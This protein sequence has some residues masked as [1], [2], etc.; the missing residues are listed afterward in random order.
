MQ[1]L[2][3]AR[4]VAECGLI[5]DG[6]LLMDAGR[7]TGLGRAGEVAIPKGSAVLD[8]RGLIAGPGLVDIHC[9][10]GGSTWCYDDPSAVGR[11]HLAGGTTSLCCSLYHA[12][13]FPTTVK[14]IGLIRRAC[15]DREPGNIVGIHFEGPYLSP[16][17]GASAATA[18]RPDPREY[19]SYLKLAEGLI[20]Q[21]SFSPEVEGI[22][23]FVDEV[24]GR[25]IAMSFAHSEAGPELIFKYARKGVSICTHLMDATGCSIVPSR[26]AGTREVGFDEAVMLCENVMTEI[27]PD[28]LGVHVR[29]L[30]CKFILQAVGID[31]IVAITDCATYGGFD[32]SSAGPAADEGRE[33][34]DINM[35]NGELCGS[36]LLMNR[37]L[38]NFMKHTG[39]GIVDAF[40]IGARNP[41]RA[42]RMLDRIGTLE[43]GKKADAILVDEEFNID[44]V[45]LDGVVVVRN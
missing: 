16:K 5:E 3:N 39:I 33:S 2:V 37:A 28:E 11:H 41:A 35:A 14:A 20:R 19:Q 31:R 15:E 32:P 24:L 7:I 25:G 6:V 45:I 44:S 22:E 13:D 12:Q 4:I 17:Y 26:W 9:H 30:M 8:G 27:I 34:S 42:I 29:P 21:W 43:I 1:A 18:R 10:G 38:R 40:R 36:R 23:A